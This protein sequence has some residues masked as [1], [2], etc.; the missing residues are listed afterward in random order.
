MLCLSILKIFFKLDWKHVVWS[1]LYK[2]GAWQLQFEVAPRSSDQ[3]HLR[4]DMNNRNRDVKFLNDFAHKLLQPVS[5]SYLKLDRCLSEK[6]ISL[7][8][9]LQLIEVFDL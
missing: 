2:D 8:L 9:K 5:P 4:A 7:L 1:I 3:V 6:F